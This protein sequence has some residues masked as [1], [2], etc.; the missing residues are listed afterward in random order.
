VSIINRPRKGDEDGV[1][2]A[3]RAT[4]GSEQRDSWVARR[5]TPWVVSDPLRPEEI[6][7]AAIFLAFDATFTNGHELPVDGGVAQL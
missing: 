2:S 5:R 3:C 6:A 7:K 4:P 1:S